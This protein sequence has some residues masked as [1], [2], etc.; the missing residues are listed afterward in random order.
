MSHQAPFPQPPNPPE[1]GEV[2]E[3]LDPVLTPLGFAPGQAGAFDREGQVI[4]CRGD[5]DGT[6]GA[7]VDL[8]IDLGARPVWR[9]TDVRYWGFPSD[10]WHLDFDANGTL[11]EQLATLARTLPITL[12]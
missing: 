5:V 6:D 11:S 9:I 12:A 4:F 2:A 8:V 7:C 1:I 10:T 3:I